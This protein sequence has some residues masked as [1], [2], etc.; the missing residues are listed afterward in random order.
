VA[1]ILG[2]VSLAGVD[3]SRRAFLLGLVLLT[4]W[5]GFIISCGGS[6]SSSSSGG[7]VTPAGSYNVTI[8]ATRGNLTH[9]FNLIV[10][11]Q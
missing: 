10:I 11:V 4:V 6:N 7:T 3:R 9:T 1:V 2:I 8:T 5:L